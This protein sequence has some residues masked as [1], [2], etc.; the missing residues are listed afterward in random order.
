MLYLSLCL[1]MH[2]LNWGLSIRGESNQFIC[3][4]TM[5]KVE[6]EFPMHTD[7]FKNIFAFLPL[8]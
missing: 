6:E 2:L 8:G 3:R 4:N 5:L 7:E 1:C